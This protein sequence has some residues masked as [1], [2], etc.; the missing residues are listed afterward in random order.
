MIN[1]KS[2]AK[3]FNL[4]IIDETIHDLNDK[5]K[6][7]QA[8]TINE[9]SH[10]EKLIDL[11][12]VVDTDDDIK[13]FLNK[14]SVVVLTRIEKLDKKI[15]EYAKSLGKPVLWTKLLKRETSASLDAYIL[16]KNQK[17]VRVHGTLL[18]V[19]GEG[20]LITGKS[21]IGKSE[22]A[23]ELV[24]RNHLFVGDDAIDIISFAGVPMGKSPRMSREF[25]EVRGVGIINLKGM[26]GI[27]SMLKEHN[28]DLVIELV[29]LD[30]VKSSI[31][32]L[33]REYVYKEIAGSE[34]PLLQ[35]PVSSGRSIASVVEAAV[36]SFKQRTQDGYIAVNDL[37]K[38]LKES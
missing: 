10:N 13:N 7:S 18:S 22:L 1:I 23:L 21:G 9:I 32:R 16:R 8:T 11:I 19:F 3:K 34:I 30:D 17:P 28:V 35:V 14:I 5:L 37:T 6:L 26:F 12:A 20:V 4:H 29:I 31:E 27:Q 33:G 24:N 15:I 38:R 2:L 25:I 36:I